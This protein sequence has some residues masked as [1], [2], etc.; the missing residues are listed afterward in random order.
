[1]SASRCNNGLTVADNTVSTLLG[2]SELLNIFIS[3]VARDQVVKSWTFAEQ[4]GEVDA[5]YGSGY[6]NGYYNLIMN[7]KS[8]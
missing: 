3:Q 7:N 8:I 4:L 6:P 1:M 5:D 2:L